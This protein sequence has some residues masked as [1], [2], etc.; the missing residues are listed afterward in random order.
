ML[1]KVTELNQVSRDHRDV[2]R[3][4]RDIS[5]EILRLQTGEALRKLSQEEQKCHQLFRLAT[6]GKDNTYEWYKDRITQRVEHTC[7]W[8]LEHDR[9]QL[10]LKQESGPLIVS[11]DPGCG[12]TVLAKYLIDHVFPRSTTVCCYFFF[13]DQDQNTIRQALCALLHQLFSQ[14]PS[15][16]THALARFR[17]DGTNLTYVTNS[18][19][20]IFLDAVN[21]PSAG[22]VTVVLDALDE[23]AETELRDLIRKN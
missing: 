11:A 12:K 13:T 4:H 2:V 18:L 19:W 23:C 1:T 5:K 6:D 9:F 7:V 3:D 16:I 15:L 17:Q 21:D 10:W 14:K 20:D 8:F 22:A